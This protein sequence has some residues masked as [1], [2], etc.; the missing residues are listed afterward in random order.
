MPSRIVNEQRQRRASRVRARIRGT[1]E[2]PRLS[3]SRTLKHISV[4]L[5]DDL[6]GRTVLAVHDNNISDAKLTGVARAKAVG[7][8]LA[9]RAKEK[10]IVTVIFDRGRFAYHGRVK[11]VAEAA[12]EGGLQF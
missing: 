7:M 8:L 12:R 2:R 9:E 6:A 10:G 5:I 4:Q 1:A 3:V 11:A